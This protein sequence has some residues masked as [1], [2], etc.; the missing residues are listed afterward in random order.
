MEYKDEDQE[1]I[2]I[3]NKQLQRERSQRNYFLD[4]EEDYYFCIFLNFYQIN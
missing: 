1:K 4:R 3:D 2:Q